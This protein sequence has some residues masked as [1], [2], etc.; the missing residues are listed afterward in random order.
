MALADPD[1]WL[2]LTAALGAA[3]VG[4]AGGIGGAVL[5][6]PGLVL[7]GVPQA[8]AASLGLLTVAAG[9]LAAAPRQLA[10]RLINHR[11]AVVLELTATIGAVAGAVLA[12]VVPPEL[13]NVV[14]AVAVLTAAAGS[15]GRRGMRNRPD[16]ALGA[17][18]VGEHPGRLA[19]VYRLGE[20]VVPYCARRV[21]AGLGLSGVVGVVAGLTGT[22]GGYLKTPLMSEV[23]HVPVKVAAATTT[24]AS[25]LTAVAALI[26]YVGRGDVDPLLGAVAV[27]GAIA[28]GMLG[29]LV[30]EVVPP[31][32]ARRVLAGALVVVAVVLVAA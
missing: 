22:S 25:G 7:A 29:A 20:E 31:V 5:L 17:D 24:L 32:L 8:L 15:F 14:L 13:F 12:G 23:M 11:L 2:V 4:A 26:V 18:E 19:G 9:S 28:G 27:I 3:A 30:Q 21:P 1:L 6:V 10:Q 16:P